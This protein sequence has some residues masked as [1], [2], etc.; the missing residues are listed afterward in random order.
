ML[1][2]CS[3]EAGPAVSPPPPPPV[4]TAPAAIVMD[5]LAMLAGDSMLPSIRVTVDGVVRAATSAEVLTTSS[6]TSVLV[7]AP[8]GALM[9]VGD[10]Q[11][12]ITVAWAAL[13]S[14]AV[15]RTLTV[16]SERLAAVALTMT[17]SLVAGDTA[18]I[19]IRGSLSSGRIVIDPASVTVASRNPAVLAIDPANRVVALS[20]GSTWV[21]ARATTG[22]ADSVLVT[23]APGAA[24]NVALTPHS[25]TLQVGDNQQLIATVTDRAHDVI[26][27]AVIAWTSSAPGV[28]TVT[29]SGLVVAVAVG[30]ANIVATSGSA[31]DTVAVTATAPALQQ[32]VAS[33]TTLSLNAGN[34]A[35]VTVQAYDSRGQSMTLPTLTWSSQMAGVTVSASGMVAAAANVGTSSVPGTVTVRSG[36]VTTTVAVSTIAAPPPP[37]PPPPSGDYVQIRWVGNVPTPSV[38][39]AFEA[40]RVRINSLFLSFHGVTAI[41]P[42]LSAG[43]C[44]AGAAALNES[45]PGIVIFAQVTAIDGPGNILGS[46]GPCLLRSGTYLPIVGAMQFDSVDM[47]SMVSNGT[48]NGVVLHEMM[49]TLGFGTIWGPGLQDEVADPNGS[50]PEYLAIGA[51]AEYGALGANAASGVP[52]ENTG[53]S[54]THGSHWRESVFRSELMTGWA[55]GSMAMS[56]VTIGALRDFGYDVDLNKADPYT[57]PSSLQAGESLRASIEIVERNRAPGWVVD[58]TGRITPYTGP[59]VH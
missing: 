56:R 16:A 44:M 55:D 47:A 29:S 18:A 20:A 48:L 14:I 52:V 10:G 17:T 15:S 11:S 24:T 42:N 19:Q 53:G 25:A 40:A 43:F 13:P 30:H 23:V 49:H 6:D 9:A 27:T 35:Q 45:V 37:P 36:S 12:T 28:A 5:T 59:V 50:D 51:Q 57:L 58:P 32:L 31:A 3:S 22:A 7:V 8:N 54:G 33:P 34:S 39:A 46:A 41:N 38:A 26:A 2:S 21:I 4:V 1:A